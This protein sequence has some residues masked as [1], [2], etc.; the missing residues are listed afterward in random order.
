MDRN[1]IMAFTKGTIETAEMMCG[2]RVSPRQA[3]TRDERIPGPGV[4]AIIGFTGEVE[5]ACVLSMPNELACFLAGYF[6]GETYEQ[7]DNDVI[8]AVQEI[9]NV[10]IG[11]ARKYLSRDGLDFNFG[12]PKTMVGTLFTTD[13]GPEYRN[14]GIR[15]SSAQQPEFLIG[16]SWRAGA[17]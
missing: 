1:V 17:N 11:A 8:D 9:D 13:D 15:F 12:L 7:I 3:K 16:L 6:I 5:G 10:L 4:H 2:M 14:L